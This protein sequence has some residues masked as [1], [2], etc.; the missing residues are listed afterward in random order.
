MNDIF[1]AHV[2]EILAETNTGLTGSQI[3]KY[4]SIYAI[5][6]NV[7]IPYAQYPFPSNV[8]NKRTALKEN[9]LRFNQQQ[10]FVIISDLCDLPYF[11]EN[12]DVAK[13]K[14]KLISQYGYLNTISK[15][16]NA[17]L[18]EKAKHWLTKYPDSLKVFDEALS[19]FENQIYERNTLDNMRLSFELLLKGIFINEKS[20]ENQIPDLGKLLKD[21]GTSV[22][23]RNMTTTLVTYYTQYQNSYIKHND[24][25]NKNEIE[26]IIELTSLMMKFL[27]KAMVKI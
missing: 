18:I 19:Q 5:E 9:L 14:I 15:F 6:F 2:S 7:D 26:Y 27:I 24:K 10:R 21:N 8:Q 11:S 12:E 25:V 23:L 3:V 22:E 20:L 1:I 4:C 17:E 13:L 16:G